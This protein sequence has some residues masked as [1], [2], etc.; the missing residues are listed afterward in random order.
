MVTEILE[1][2]RKKIAT[3]LYIDL[4]LAADTAPNANDST[5]S[6]TASRHL[7]EVEHV[8]AQLVLQWVTASEMQ[9][10]FLYPCVV[11]A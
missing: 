6:C 9:L 4:A 8:P 3:N 10:S 1:L 7:R 5:A 2:L 11:S